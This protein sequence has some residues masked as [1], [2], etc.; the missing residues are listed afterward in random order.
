MKAYQTILDF[1]LGCQS[2]S[3]LPTMARTQLWFGADAE[4]DTYLHDH[5][6]TEW[7]AAE[8]GEL[9]PWQGFPGGRLAL[10]I[11]LDQFS[12]KLFRSSSQAYQQDQQAQQICVAGLQLGH[13]HQLSLTERLFYY[14]PLQHAENQQLQDYSVFAYA[15]LSNVALAETNALFETFFDNAI[16]N[17]KIINRFGRFPDRNV[18][19]CRDSTAEELEYLS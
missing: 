4:V 13:D 1:W 9:L 17:Q 11:I 12:R 7:Q 6:F 16:R 10:I 8:K 15:A 2:D 3:P 14:M 18:I 5:F 19:L